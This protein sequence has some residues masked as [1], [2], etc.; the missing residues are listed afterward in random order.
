MAA[1]LSTEDAELEAEPLADRISEAKTRSRQLWPKAL[2]L[3]VLA[4]ILT[5]VAWREAA[6]GTAA[7]WTAQLVGQDHSSDQALETEP[8]LGDD[9]IELASSRRRRRRNRRRNRRRRTA[10]K[11]GMLAIAN[12]ARRRRNWGDDKDLTACHGDCNWELKQTGDSYLTRD[13][14]PNELKCF[15]WGVPPGC[16]GKALSGWGYCYADQHTVLM[17]VSKKRS[18]TDLEILLSHAETPRSVDMIAVSKENLAWHLNRALNVES[19]AQRTALTA[20]GRRRVGSYKHVVI[21]EYIRIPV[22]RSDRRRN[23]GKEWEESKNSVVELDKMIRERGGQTVLFQTWASIDA[24]DEEM[25]T[26][27]ESYRRYQSALTRR[28]RVQYSPLI[29]P[30]G[31]AYLLWKKERPDQF[32]DLWESDLSHESELARYYTALV[33]YQTITGDTC[34][35]LPGPVDMK[36]SSKDTQLLQELAHKA[37][38]DTL[39]EEEE[40][41]LKLLEEDR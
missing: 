1:L 40:W 41:Q 35:G 26:I 15:R 19:S 21:Q 27:K 37:V 12:N 39:A 10:L 33:F 7:R 23:A 28:R 6:T 4:A 29:A 17:I 22:Y 9:T 24:F 2:F 18:R 20:H 34:V 3:F 14:C 38:L 8:E 25:P 11:S 32:L 16:S 5:A 30:V 13:N 31:Y 36:L